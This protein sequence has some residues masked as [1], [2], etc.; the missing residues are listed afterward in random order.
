V[1]GTRLLPAAYLR[2][3]RSLTLAVCSLLAL[4]LVALG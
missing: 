4:G 1:L 3:R 2:L